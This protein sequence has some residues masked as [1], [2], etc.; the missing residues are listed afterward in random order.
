M[1]GKKNYYNSIE[2]GI[3]TQNTKESRSN[4][5]AFL[6]S[7]GFDTMNFASYDSEQFLD[8]LKQ[9]AE[10]LKATK[11]GYIT[12]FDPIS[13]DIKR[14]SIPGNVVEINQVRDYIN[15]NK[16]D[17]TKFKVSFTERIL[18]VPNSFCGTV[19]TDGSGNTIIE[20]LKG[21]S[22]IMELTSAGVD[23]SKT[24][25][26]EFYDFEKVFWVPQI[27]N[28][29]KEQCQCFRGYYEFIYGKV[30]DRTSI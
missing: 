20:I 19:I 30:N 6:K 27:I 24:E 2:W 14:C 4:G 18:D 5:I 26:F 23:A 15:D 12:I 9:I 25:F 17:L 11:S 7:Y 13:P 29:I 21:S 3:I 10:M 22:N 8:N 16:I 28:I 1:E